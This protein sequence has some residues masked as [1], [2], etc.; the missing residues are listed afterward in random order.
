MALHMKFE[1]SLCVT[2]ELP[3]GV[4]ERLLSLDVVG[5]P[6]GDGTRLQFA[7]TFK[8][9]IPVLFTNSS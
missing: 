8:N 9:A 4:R 5:Q 1:C 2:N 7:S 6:Q 3:R